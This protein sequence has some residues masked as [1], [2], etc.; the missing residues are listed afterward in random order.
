MKRGILLA[1]SLLLT[2]VAW[3]VQIEGVDPTGRL[4]AVGVTSTGRFMVDTSTGMSQHVIVDSGT[5]NVQDGQIR[6][7]QNPADPAYRVTSTG[8]N[9]SV[10]AATCSISVAN[11]GVLLSGSGTIYPADTLRKQGFVCNDSI[12]ASIWLSAVN[13]PEIYAGTCMSPDNPGAFTGALTGISTATA[14]Y[15]YW[16][17]K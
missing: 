12:T 10:T 15:S 4:K 16:Y 8:G 6:A 3:G 14:N 7:Y 11:A 5:I 9:F 17:C 2:P 13:G 1:L